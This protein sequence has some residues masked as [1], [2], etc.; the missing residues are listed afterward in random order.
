VLTGLLI[1][2]LMGALGLAVESSDWFLT[3]RALQN[4]ADTAVLAAAQNQGQTCAAGGTSCP[5]PIISHCSTTAKDGSFDCEAVAAAQSY[6]FKDASNNVTLSAYY[7]TS[8]CPN[9]VTDCYKVIISRKIPV[10]FLALVGFGG[11]TTIG[12]QRATLVTAT[13][14]A[15]APSAV[16]EYCITALKLTGTGIV[17]KGAPNANQ[18]CNDF[19]NSST[20]CSGHAIGTYVDAVVTADSACGTKGAALASAIT[21]PEGSLLDN[22]TS[23][24]NTD[25]T[26][27]S[28]GSSFPGVTLSGTVD[29]SASQYT[30]YCGNVTLSGNVT[31]KSGSTGAVIVIHNGTLNLNGYTF[32]SASAAQNGGTAAGVTLLFTGT[33]LTDTG[34][35]SI[36][37]WPSGL[38][39]LDIAAPTTG[40][41]Q[42]MVIY[43]NPNLTASIYKENGSGAQCSGVSMCYNPSSGPTYDL[44]G[45]IY[46]PN[47]QTSFQGSVN[48]STNGYN[49]I[50]IIVST[51]AENGT[52]MILY[53]GQDAQS[54][55][56]QAGVQPP[57][58]DLGAAYAALIQ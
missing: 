14:W 37:Y 24:T 8:G 6:G 22:L 38:G 41:W 40:T 46:M 43:Q 42:G 20:N 36:S 17:S 32:Q 3:Q 30:D 9:S 21:V 23:G 11:D 57:T 55:C 27:N 4:A 7:L 10:A 25:P 29:L 1:V 56:H 2:P 34:S 15:R 47:A 52:G 5:S 45:T 12:S 58:S 44:T 19:S 31:V 49:C 26:I 48:Q 51:F 35:T 18:K 50:N 13:S 53:S 16:R 33:S 28:C 39:T 54:Q